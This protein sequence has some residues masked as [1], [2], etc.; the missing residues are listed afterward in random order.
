MNNLKTKNIEKAE[1][2]RGKAL[3]VTYP[4]DFINSETDFNEIVEFLSHKLKNTD[5]YLIVLDS[6]NS[7]RAFFTTNIPFD[8][9]NKDF[10]LFEKNGQNY[11]GEIC[12]ISSNKNEHKKIIF[13]FMETRVLYSSTFSEM[14][15]FPPAGMPD[16]PELIKFAKE[17]NYQVND[18][19]Y[20]IGNN[21]PNEMKNINKHKSTLETLV[22]VFNPRG[23]IVKYELSRFNLTTEQKEFLDN[24]DSTSKTL[25][26][27]GKAGSGKTSFAKALLASRF[28]EDEILMITNSEGLESLSPTHKAIILD[29][30]D[31]NNLPLVMKQALLDVSEDT[32]DISKKYKSVSI[33]PRT[34]KIVLTSNRKSIFSDYDKNALLKGNDPYLSYSKAEVES[35]ERRVYE[36]EINDFLFNF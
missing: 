17:N 15:L 2:F 34:V 27:Y 13:E 7:V 16:Y 20:W 23:I 8:I 18:L 30:F 28:K 25:L 4:S 6:N 12:C 35:L 36:L 24:W 33:P 26:L 32:K 21:F 10:F 31:W 5:K 1:R 22:K 14:E 9:K 19:L 3:L 29:D 11:P